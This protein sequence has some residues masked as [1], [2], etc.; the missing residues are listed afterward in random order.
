MEW[1]IILET[2]KRE[3]FKTCGNKH[4][5]IHYNAEPIGDKTQ[6]YVGKA[7]GNKHKMI[8]YNAE[9]IG[10]TTKGRLLTTKDN[11]THVPSIILKL[12][13]YSRC[14]TI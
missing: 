12:Y 13:K 3:M 14:T 6:K 7:C 4:K 5:M 11:L 8:H 2:Q 1:Q 9:P 10:D